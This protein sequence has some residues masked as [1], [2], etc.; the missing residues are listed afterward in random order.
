[1]SPTVEHLDHSYEGNSPEN[2]N[3][4]PGTSSCPFTLIRHPLQAL[5]HDCMERDHEYHLNGGFSEDAARHFATG[6][7]KI[8]SV[9]PLD[10]VLHS[11]TMRDAS[12]I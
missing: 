2:R 6:Q 1:M 8:V 3:M 4:V 7:R 12:L 5:Y 11:M 9:E 10:S